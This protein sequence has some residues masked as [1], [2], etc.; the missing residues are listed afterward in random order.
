M[1]EDRFRMTAVNERLA[2]ASMLRRQHEAIKQL[3][4]ALYRISENPY[5]SSYDDACQALEDTEGL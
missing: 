2:A 1:L 5:G 3:R 4:E